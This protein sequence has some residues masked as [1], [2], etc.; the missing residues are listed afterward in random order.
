M[1]QNVV[2][3]AVA[4]T[5]GCAFL[6]AAV[7]CSSSSSSVATPTPTPTDAMEEGVVTENPYENLQ[8]GLGIVASSTADGLTDSDTMSTSGTLSHVAVTVLLEND[9]I[10]GSLLDEHEGAVSSVDG[11]LALPAEIYSKR[12][13]GD[14]YGLRSYSSIG[15]EWYEQADAFCKYIQG[16]TCE[17]VMAIEVDEYGKT[18][19]ADLAAGCT[20]SITSFQEAV[21]K[22][23][24]SAKP[25]CDMDIDDY[26]NY[27]NDSTGFWDDLVDGTEDVL[28]GVED[29]VN[30]VVDGTGSAVDDVMDGTNNTMNA[31]DNASY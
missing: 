28:D 21:E 29:G 25:V 7:G 14:T 6:V 13:L 12:E 2:T 30:D 11:G 3:R 18:T 24:E 17:E 4:A 19:E 5:L 20:I 31:T 1:K 10:C 15:K 8:M 9:V 22:A 26:T 23:C 27:K 16:M